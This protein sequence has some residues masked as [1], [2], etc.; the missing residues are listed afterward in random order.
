VPEADLGPVTKSFST[1]WVF[2]LGGGRFISLDEEY[3][4]V[5]EPMRAPLRE[6][7]LKAQKG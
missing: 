6:A 2:D 4:N 7:L 5:S 3:N 1:L